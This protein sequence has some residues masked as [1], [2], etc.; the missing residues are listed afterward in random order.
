MAAIRASKVDQL[1]DAAKRTLLTLVVD[2]T[3]KGAFAHGAGAQPPVQDC[4]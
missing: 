2:P 4:K 3:R 1:A